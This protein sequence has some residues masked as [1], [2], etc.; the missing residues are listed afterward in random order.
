MASTPKRK[1]S[2]SSQSTQ[3]S[4]NLS[5][6][7]NLS[8]FASPVAQIKHHA[9]GN[10]TGVLRKVKDIAADF[11]NQILKWAS[12]NTQGVDIVTQIGNIKIEK[13]FNVQS[14][15]EDSSSRIPTLPLELN[16]LCD[17]LCG[18]VD[19]MEK[20]EQKLKG[21]VDQIEGL[22]SLRKFQKFESESSLMFT[23]MTLDDVAETV[24]S[25]HACYAKELKF[26]Q[27]L[28]QEVAHAGSREASMV[29]TLSWLHQPYIDT[30]AHDGLT[31]LLKET[32]HVK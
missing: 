28:V 9:A 15:Q 8:L 24:S 10:L 31:A 17:Q 32:G 21:K 12:L 3:N 2:G 13:V 6:S 25:I 4:S 20:I 11:H 27:Q 1:E 18:L 30:Q 14:S 19:V 16:P 23:T 5:E 22:K 29:Y 26:K 7:L